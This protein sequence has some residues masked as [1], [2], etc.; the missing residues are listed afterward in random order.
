[1]VQVPFEKPM[2]ESPSRSLP[3]ALRLS[4]KNIYISLLVAAALLVPTAV[5][6]QKTD[7]KS[8]FGLAWRV[9]GRW[10]IAGNDKSISE[11][12][13]VPPGALLEPLEDGRNHSIT[14]LLPDGQR[15]V[16]GCF[17]SRDCERGFRVPSLFR[18]PS[19]TATDLL[20]R[21][22]AVMFK[23]DSH[24][25]PPG[26]PA[27][28]R[29]EAAVLIGSGNR[30]EIAGLAAALSEGTYS[31]VV[32][33]VSQ[34]SGQEVRGVFEKRGRSVSLPVQAEG[35]FEVLIFDR[36]NTPRIDLLLA[37]VR[38]LRGNKL[39][40]SFEDVE[41]ILKD[42]NEDYQ[43]WP[44]HEL[45][46]AYLES[47]TLGIDPATDRVPKLPSSWPQTSEATCE[48]TFEPAPG[49]LKGD[50]EV[51]LECSNQGAIIH[52]TVDESQPLEGT[53][54]YRAPI[55]VKGTGL[56]IKAFASVPGK[57]D[58]PVVTGIFRIGE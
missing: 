4:P 22:N 25:M 32:R 34:R 38:P 58:S 16:Y 44:I 40:K 43:G 21:V 51:K 9:I 35:L 50:T 12:D 52:F 45:R 47:V 30:V 46:R 11:G 28:S 56:T 8:S 49:V 23:Q 2:R 14:I 31:Y 41:A 10:H 33:P 20:R 42:W 24:V 57:K 17:A 39:I 36:L 26:D 7:S 48:P 1:M 15:V 29:D 6:S 13:A 18:K 5:S 19:S 37:A 3:S 53:S 27:G 55:V 54:V